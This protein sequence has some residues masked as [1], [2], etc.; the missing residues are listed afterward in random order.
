MFHVYFDFSVGL[1]EPIV[2]PT[3]WLDRVLAHVAKVEATL[4]IER[5]KY[6]NN[7]VHW[8][9]T[10]FEGVPDK[11]LCEIAGDHNHWVRHVYDNLT[12]WSKNPPG[13]GE[14]LTPEQAEEFWPALEM[15]DVPPARW[16]QDY[17]KSRMK[18]LFDVMTGKEREG[19]TFG[20]KKLS[21]KQAGAVILLFEQYLDKYDTR[22]SVPKGCDFL[23][24]DYDWCEKCSAAI[25]LGQPCNKRGCPL[26]EPV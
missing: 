15:I 13:G 23:T 24:D 9:R 14:P 4:G 25:Y 7:P 6:L 1:N 21:P 8:T 16:T 19:V 22:L 26:V 17:Y 18:H 10:T 3:G 20:E 5:Q 12:S 2:V 11:V